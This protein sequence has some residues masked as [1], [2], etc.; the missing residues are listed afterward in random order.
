MPGVCRY[1]CVSVYPFVCLSLCCLLA[2]LVKKKL[3]KYRENFGTDVH[4]DK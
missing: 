1:V 2:N 4:V 3:L